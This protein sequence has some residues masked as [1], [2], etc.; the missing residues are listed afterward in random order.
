MTTITGPVSHSWGA[1]YTGPM[2]FRPYLP[3]QAKVV[4]GAVV[5]GAA[6]TVEWEDG[7]PA[8]TL[9]LE[10]G[11]YS[12]EMRGTDA[13][14]IEVP[15]ETGT[16]A[17]A[18]LVTEEVA[19]G[20]IATAL[21]LQYGSDYWTMRITGL[22]DEGYPIVA[23]AK[24]TRAATGAASKLRLSYQGDTWEMRITSVT[25]GWPTIQWVKL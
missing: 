6:V 4:G 20:G 23:F 19:I 12:V 22:T 9:T 25:G 8:D 2:T 7:E 18:D 13:F 11:I 24:S 1:D 21:S 10:E 5:S 16:S 3:A 17:L 14:R 15:A